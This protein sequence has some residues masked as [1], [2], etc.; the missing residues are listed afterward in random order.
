LRKSQIGFAAL[1]VFGAVLFAGA[2]RAE[3]T[4]GTA[5]HPEHGEYLTDSG[6]MAL[7]LFEEDR[8]GGDRGRAVE[9]DCLDEC[10][11]R[12][13]PVAAN[14][15]LK[16]EGSADAALLGSF[17]RPDG[18][19]QATYNGWPLYTFA[20]D[21]VPGDINGHDFEEFGGEWYLVTPEGGALGEPDEH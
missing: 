11:T 9:S 18:K 6:G 19:V 21:F 12:W 14:P 7:Y 17:T 10:L 13:P 3:T 16:A 15:P 1:L 5:D 2:S 20:E 8:R 4:I